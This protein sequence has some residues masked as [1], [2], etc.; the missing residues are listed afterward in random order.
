MI[1]IGLAILR[2]TLAVVLAIHGAHTL[3]GFW[4]GPGAG[5]GGLSPTASHFASI[6]LEPGMYMAVVAGVIQLV[7]GFLLAVGFLTRWAAAAVLGYLAI[8]SWKQHAPWGFF[9][10]WVNDPT[11]GH[12]MEYAIVLMSALFLFVL[13]GGGDFSID[14]RRSQSAAARAAGRAR[15]RNR[16]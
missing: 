8:S 15:L 5:P 12:G 4:G 2:L 11:R 13:A 10:N 6:G 3:F 7:G 14:G 1:A 9:L 16:P